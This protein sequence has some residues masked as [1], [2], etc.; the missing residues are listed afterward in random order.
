MIEECDGE[1]GGIDWRVDMMMIM[2]D[3]DDMMYMM[4]ELRM[5]AFAQYHYYYY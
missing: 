4:M 2:G 3:Y 1:Y 5:C